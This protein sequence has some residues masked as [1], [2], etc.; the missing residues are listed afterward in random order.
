MG[1]NDISAGIQTVEIRNSYN[2]MYSRKNAD[3]PS[4]PE[5]ST[6]ERKHQSASIKRPNEATLLNW[7]SRSS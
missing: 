6:T 5:L 3:D 7:R 4:H 2:S 1:S